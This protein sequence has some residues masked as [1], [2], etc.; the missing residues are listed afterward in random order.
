MSQVDD[1]SIKLLGA[2]DEAL[3]LNAKGLFDYPPLTDQTRAFL[4]SDREFLWFAIT[5][6]QAVGFVSA[7][8]ILHPDKRPHLFINELAVHNDWRRQ[9]IAT[10]L[11][12]TVIAFGGENALCPVWLAAEGDDQQAQAFYRSLS[13]LSERGAVVFEWE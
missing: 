12:E 9:G 2:T 11:I 1:L 13:E 8:S 7:T 4:K 6:G 10:K 5:D 3:I